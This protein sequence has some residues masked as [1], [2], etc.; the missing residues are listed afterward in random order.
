MSVKEDHQHGGISLIGRQIRGQSPDWHDSACSD[1]F[2]D[3]HKL[4][5]EPGCFFLRFIYSWET[6]RER[7]RHRPREKQA[8]CREPDVR[9]DPRTPGSRPGLKAGGKLLSHPGVPMQKIFKNLVV[10]NCLYSSP[11]FPSPSF[12]KVHSEITF[13]TSLVERFSM[14]LVLS[15]TIG[16]K[17]YTSVLG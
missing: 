12:S 14:W 1:R 15:N 6:Q 7:Q 2:R 3:F 4:A 11:N 10:V 16:G 8:P 9:L 5:G 17:K 13:P